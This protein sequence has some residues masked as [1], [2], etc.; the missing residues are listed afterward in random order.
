V[1]SFRRNRDA[2]VVYD[3]LIQSE[4]K[5]TVDHWNPLKILFDNPHEADLK[6]AMI[7]FPMSDRVYMLKEMLAYIG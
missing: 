3:D 1:E 2:K 5:R 7:T 6:A 4:R